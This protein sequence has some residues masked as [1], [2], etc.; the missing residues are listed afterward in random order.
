MRID[1]AIQSY[2]TP[3]KS[4]NSQGA[5]RISSVDKSP[6]KTQSD[7]VEIS[8]EAQDRIARVKAR[9][10]AGYYNSTEVNDDISEKLSRYFDEALRDI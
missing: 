5:K 7:R 9:I 3:E 6:K 2:L 4:Q 1:A 10:D 8:P